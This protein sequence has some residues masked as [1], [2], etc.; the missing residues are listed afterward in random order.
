[1]K[2]A[3]PTTS[4][5]PV[6]VLAV[7]A[8]ALGG[9]GGQ[10]VDVVVEVD[11]QPVSPSVVSSALNALAASD[12]IAFAGSSLQGADVVVGAGGVGTVTCP[13]AKMYNSS[14][15]LCV[16]CLAGAYKNGTGIACTPCSNGTYSGAG[17]V[18][19]TMCPANTYALEGS[20]S[21]TGC[22]SPF[23]S[24]AGA[25][26]CRCRLGYRP[27]PVVPNTCV[28][29]PPG[30]YMPGYATTCQRCLAPP[31]RRR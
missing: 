31:A 5:L 9:A 16:P 19:C 17:A 6:F 27:D 13:A 26:E 8:A 23:V 10:Q 15:G 7:L 18:K 29:C 24:G 1:M 3:D 4:F 25:S 12:P 14:L 11:G 20:A 22:P 21:C 30:T 28:P 2:L